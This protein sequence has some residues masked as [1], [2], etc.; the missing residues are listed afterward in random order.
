MVQLQTKLGALAIGSSVPFGLG[1]KVLAWGRNDM[2]TNQKMGWHLIVRDP[3]GVV[4]LDRLEWEMFWTGPGLEQGFI[5]PTFVLDMPGDWTVTLDL[6]MNYDSPI[7]V[8]TYE[9]L[10][11]VV[12]IEPF[13]GTITVKQLEYDGVRTNIPVY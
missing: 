2:T 11:C 5:S 6:L 10:L 7:I 4:A 1:A 13:A 3:D 8:D 12:E 9:G